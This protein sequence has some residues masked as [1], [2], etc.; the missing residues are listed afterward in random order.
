MP[1][2]QLKK[3]FIV[4][5]FIP[6]AG[7]PHRCVFCNQH[8]TTGRRASLPDLGHHSRGHPAFSRFSSGP[9]ALDRDLLL[10]GNFLGLP[11][12]RVQLLLATA[13]GYVRRGEADGIRF[14]TRPDTIAMDRLQWLAPFPV[15]TIELG[16]QSMS[17]PVLE[18]SRRGHTAENVREAVR[19]LKRH[20]YALGLQMMVGLPG[21]TPAA[22]LATGRQVAALAPDFVRIYPTLV[23]SG[24]RLAH[25][26]ARG[27]YTPMPLNAAVALVADLYR[28]FARHAIPVIRMGLQAT[29]DLSSASELVA[30]PFHPAFGELVRS[31]LWLDLI[32]NHVQKRGLLDGEIRISVHPR[33]LSQVKGQQDANIRMLIERFNLPGVEVRSNPDLP[34]ASV[35]V[36][37]VALRLDGRPVVGAVRET[38]H[39]G[40]WA[41]RGTV[42]RS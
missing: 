20:P 11:P 29:A 28:I 3:P 16:V 27:R 19:L 37:G 18:Q 40:R 31:A 33:L 7:C 13:A 1:D 10:R 8:S 5:I 35:T 38:A 36:N 42:D 26:H 12:E 25:W 4:P 15:T 23:L 32:A 21:D 41:E 30:G 17:D 9:R 22:S 6:H 34:G 24:S 14:S 39:V 2:A